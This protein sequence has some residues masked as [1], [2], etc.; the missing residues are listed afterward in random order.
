LFDCVDL[1]DHRAINQFV[2]KT[3][4]TPEE[5]RNIGEIMTHR[6]PEWERWGM[7]NAC[8]F[9][10]RRCDIAVIGLISNVNQC[11]NFRPNAVI[12]SFFG[13]CPLI[14]PPVMYCKIGLGF[15]IHP[16]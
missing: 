3:T 8:S 4:T 12:K 9:D 5:R 7:C 10:L 14:D 16:L 11:G 6:I 15:L 13:I 2:G 1:H